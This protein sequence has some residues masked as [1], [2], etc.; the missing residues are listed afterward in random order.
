[1]PDVFISYKREEKPRCARIA[2]KL[3]ELGLDVWF[4]A[5]LESGMSFDREIE[6]KVTAAKAVLVLWSPLSINSDWVRAEAGIGKEKNK[7]VAIQLAPCSLPIAFRN[8]HFETIHEVDFPDTHPGWLKVLGRIATLTGKREL[9]Y[10]AKALETV[11]TPKMS[12]M[13]VSVALLAGLALG[14]GGGFLGGRLTAPAPPADVAT[15]PVNPEVPPE[16]LL[17]GA[18]QGGWRLRDGGT[19]DA[20]AYTLSVA[21]RTLKFGNAQAA[22]EEE[23]VAVSADGWL[24]TKAQSG[25]TS[26]WKRDGTSLAYQIGDD[27]ATLTPFEACPV[28]AP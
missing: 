25:L 20:D 24:Q 5:R 11:D 14:G 10:F 28:K 26:K 8:T 19:C 17:A 27:A 21:G 6:E 3:R 18:M 7:L 4:D 9:Q 13:P 23:I 16:L 1:M 12:R 2:E 22:Q 15:Q